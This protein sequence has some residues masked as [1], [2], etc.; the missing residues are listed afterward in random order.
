MRFWVVGRIVQF[1]WNLPRRFEEEVNNVY[2][3]ED[4]EKRAEKSLDLVVLFSFVGE[5]GGVISLFLSHSL[6]VQSFLFFFLS[7]SSFT[8]PLY[9]Y[10]FC[11]GTFPS[12]SP[13]DFCIISLFLL[14]PASSQVSFQ[15]YFF[16]VVGLRGQGGGAA[17][18]GRSVL[19]LRPT[20]FMDCIIVVWIMAQ[21]QSRQNCDSKKPVW[22]LCLQECMAESSSNEILPTFLKNCQ[23]GFLWYVY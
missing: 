1:S 5:G 3:S 2:C 12:A 16:L 6:Y 20:D 19:L 11:N 7:P 14:V 4:E 13:L 8:F 22:G 18:A 15:P 9:S 17:V 21:I 23:C 10:H